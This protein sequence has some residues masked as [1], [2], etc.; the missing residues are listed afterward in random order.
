MQT[1]FVIIASQRTGST[2]LRM[3]L[4]GLRSVR[5]HGEVFLGKYRAKDGFRNFLSFGFYR[6]YFLVTT[7]RIGRLIT[8]S[9]FL[10]NKINMYLNFLYKDRKCSDAFQD[11]KEAKNYLPNENFDIQE[12]VGFKLMY[13]Q[14]YDLNYIVSWVKKYNVKIIHLT[15]ENELEQYLSKLKMKKTK[16]AHS[17]TSEEINL[18]FEIDL[19]QF[20]NYCFKEKKY[21]KKIDK[22]FSDQHIYKLSYE[23]IDG[24][25]ENLLNFLKVED[26]FTIEKEV[27]IKKLSKKSLKDQI[28]NYH[29]VL[30]FSNSE[31]LPNPKY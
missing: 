24:E 26:Q 27:S 6:I 20:E 5:C 21:E 13:D 3:K 10:N 30:E 2:L 29:E 1:K 14:L 8:P 15:R 31:K 9:F 18:K 17:S 28:S 22:L 4:N 19:K 7:K 23:N 16:L 12:S 11:F 25:F